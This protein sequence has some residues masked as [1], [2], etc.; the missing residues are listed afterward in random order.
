MSS[1]KQNK[2]W[3]D[4]L[5]AWESGGGNTAGADD[6]LWEKLQT[7]LQPYSMRRRTWL[8][9]AA[10]II[11]LLTGSFLLWQLT[12]SRP[13]APSGSAIQG[14]HFLAGKQPGKGEKTGELTP[15]AIPTATTALKTAPL[16]IAIQHDTT[17]VG[18]VVPSLPVRDTSPV[19][20]DAPVQSI[21][22][23]EQPE[24]KKKLKIVHM[25]EWNA[26]PPPTYAALK[27]SWDKSRLPA[28]PDHLPI[29]ERS[30]WPGKNRSRMP[31][32]SDN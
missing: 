9:R 7:R 28:D 10:V 2:G 25:N 20:A 4:N 29:P 24:Q 21:A 16:R 22:I 18:P 12:G 19:L 8:L 13:A 14:K 5:L 1:E 23:P 17:G 30:I 31:A 26:P 15:E 6:R 32:S 27:E 11:L 3:K